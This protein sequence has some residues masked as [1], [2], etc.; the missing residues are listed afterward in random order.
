MDA[1]LCHRCLHVNRPQARYCATCGLRIPTPP[2]EPKSPPSEP[3]PPVTAW[4]LLAAVFLGLNGPESAQQTA[5]V[6]HSETSNTGLIFD[7]PPDLPPS[8]LDREDCG[9]S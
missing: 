4:V 9:R 7:L 5:A 2:P 1:A 8:Y 3:G 6:A